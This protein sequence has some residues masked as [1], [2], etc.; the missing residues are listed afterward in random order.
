MKVILLFLVILCLVPSASARDYALEGATTNITID[1]S[2]IVHVEE[3]ISYV[4]EGNY[5]EVFRTLDVPPGESIRNIEGHCSDEAC[6]FRVEPTSEGYELIG[7]LPNSTPEEV[8][9]LFPMITM[10]QSRSTKIFPNFTTSS[11]ARNGRN[12][13]EA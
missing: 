13:L 8:T 3:S 12:L 9:F 11:G 6:T 7:E 4:F 10:V 2:G 5:N 1:S